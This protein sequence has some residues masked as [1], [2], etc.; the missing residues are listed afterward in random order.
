MCLVALAWNVNP[1]YPLVLS[2]NRDEFFK[3][4]SKELH[5]WP[6]GFYGG[7]D[8]RSGGT[9]LGFHPK[10]HW[11]LLTNY[12]DFHDKRTYT[13]SRGKLVQAFLDHPMNPEE[14]LNGLVPTLDSYDGFNLLVSDGKELF[15]LSNYGSGI[16]KM[17]PGVHA[18]SNGLIND[19][20]PK[21]ELAKK[22]LR[23]TIKK[24]FDENDVLHTLKSRDTYP[25]QD[26]PNTGVTKD[27]EIGLSSQLIR[28]EDYYGT[29]SSMAVIQ[30]KDG[31]VKMKQR[32]YKEDFHI[33]DET[34]V[35]FQLQND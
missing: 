1:D 31:H 27:L 23:A 24:S 16:Q 33:F 30:N 12:R 7:Q 9:W 19:P 25:I 29:V 32:V 28:I 17:N 21:V 35:E 26:L 18:L 8:L 34:R 2:T 10:G 14:Y 3:R 11:A 13:N 15:Y 4:P 20:W 5:Q 22:Q 6:S